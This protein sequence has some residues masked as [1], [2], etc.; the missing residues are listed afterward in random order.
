MVFVRLCSTFLQPTSNRCVCV[1][2]ICSTRCFFSLLS[3]A[4]PQLEIDNLENGRLHRNLIMRTLRQTIYGGR[5]EESIKRLCVCMCFFFNTHLFFGVALANSTTFEIHFRINECL[6]R[7]RNDF[8][9]I[10]KHVSFMQ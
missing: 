7:D 10:S 5:F 2:A 6:N 9:S 8:A 1:P 4:D 3:C